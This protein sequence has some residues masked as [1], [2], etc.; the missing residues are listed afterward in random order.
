MERIKSKRKKNFKSVLKLNKET[1]KKGEVY[2]PIKY[3]F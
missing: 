3:N 2:H 1:L